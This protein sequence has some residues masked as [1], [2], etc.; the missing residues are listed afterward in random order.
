MPSDSCNQ[1]GFRILE[2]DSDFFGFTVGCLTE[3]RMDGGRLGGVLREL[4]AMGCRL[5][6]W[7]SDPEDAESQRVAADH[8]GFLAD[9]KLTFTLDIATR[10]VPSCAS[11]S[12]RITEFQSPETSD[13]LYRLALQSGVYSRF[14]VD[15]RFPRHL[16]EKLYREWIRKSVSHELAHVVLVAAIGEATVGLTTLGTKGG[17]NIGLVAVDESA[18]GQHVGTALMSAAIERFRELGCR[19]VQVVTQGANQAASRLYQRCGFGIERTEYFHHF[20][21]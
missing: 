14:Y 7:P 15:P 2:W 11:S 12:A 21:L 4:A 5:V 10:P 8:G 13:I 17:G 19:R 1:R 16:Y 3:P 18:R 6:Y 9:R 20:W